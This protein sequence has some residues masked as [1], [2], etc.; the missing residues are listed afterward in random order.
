M[1]KDSLYIEI[2]K[3]QRE[4]VST[5]LKSLKKKHKKMFL[6]K[7]PSIFYKVTPTGIGFGITVHESHSKQYLDITDYE[8]W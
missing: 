6:N 3:K 7:D 2:S 1:N 8:T 4:Q 5:W